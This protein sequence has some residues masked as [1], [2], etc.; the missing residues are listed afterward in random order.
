MDCFLDDWPI[1]EAAEHDLDAVAPFVAPLVVFDDFLA[2][3]PARDAGAYPSVFQGFSK[4]V[5]VVAAI[6]EQPFDIR[7]AAEQCPCT[8]VVTDLTL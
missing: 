3:L 6:P 1:L 4:P 2:G 8:D 7:Q 5:G